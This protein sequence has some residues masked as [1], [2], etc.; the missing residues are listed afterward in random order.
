MSTSLSELRAALADQ[1][2]AIQSESEWDD[3]TSHGEAIARAKDAWQL[4]RE[5]RLAR[6]TIDKDKES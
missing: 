6:E 2:E 4:Q 3:E 1:S 5:I